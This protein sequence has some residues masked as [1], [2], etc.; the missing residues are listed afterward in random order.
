MIIPNV[1]YA[2]K[3]VKI[4]IDV[5]MIY[6]SDDYQ[7]LDKYKG[8]YAQTLN[9]NVFIGISSN[10]ESINRSVRMDHDGM[11]LT[12]VV[13]GEGE[14]VSAGEC[15]R[16]KS[17]T[18]IFRHCLMDY[19]LT[20]F[21]SC[22]HRRCYLFIPR[23]LFLLLVEM[24]PVLKTIPPVMPMK[25]D[26]SHFSEFIALF[27]RIKSCEN[28][29]F[30]ALLPYIEG[31]LKHFLHSYIEEDVNSLLRRACSILEEDFTSSLPDIAA[32]LPMNYNTFRKSFEKV[33]G[34]SPSQYRI[35]ARCENAKQLLSMGF[36]ISKVAYRNGYPD[37]YTF[38]HQFTKKV[39]QS[40]K[41]Y[42]KE[43]IF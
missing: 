4:D 26:E 7:W 15:Y 32:S 27:E 17:D 43:H 10:T 24:H 13:T 35:N 21:P 31:Y 6:M 33:Y 2:K 16:I 5:K 42:R 8:I 41:E 3:L 29:N 12:W 28:E 23:S 39:G 14:L 9:G 34:I 11:L 1:N 18:L 20:L 25:L 38:S 37:L 36:P 19:R 30:L 22:H 40:P